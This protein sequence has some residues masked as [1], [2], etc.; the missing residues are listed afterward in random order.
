M[1]HE[2]IKTIVSR[3][4][5]DILQAGGT[6]RI[7]PPIPAGVSN[8][9]VHLSEEDLAKL[10]KNGLTKWRDLS[11]P[12]Q[13]A[14]QETVILAGP[15]GTLEKVRVLGPA[16][17]RSQAEITVSDAYQLGVA[18]LVRESGKIAGT[19]G[20][21]II[22]SD[23]SVQIDE[24]VIV[25]QRHLH[26]TPEDA[27]VFKVKDGDLVE[28]A[29]GEARALIFDQVIVRV[30]PDYQLAF[31]IDFEEANAAG[32]KQDD[33]VRL[34]GLSRS[35]RIDAQVTEEPANRQGPGLTLITEEVAR[36]AQ[37]SLYLTPG[38]LITPLAR[39]MI[40][41]RGIEVITLK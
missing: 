18:A 21:T 25:A 9:H 17:K 36:Q 29:A 24:G 5:A 6:G 8:R 31:H 11:Q 33:P 32:L 41:E 13:F 12:G 10:F 1:E 38:G 4:A 23:G 22:G 35:S 39:D 30:S 40:R 20:I 15:K 7:G 3:V 16:R 19:P 27:E 28:I 34:V 37:G 2:L 14:A 26:M